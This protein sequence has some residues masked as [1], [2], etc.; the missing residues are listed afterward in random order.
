MEGER[1]K[2]GGE[3]GKI[4]RAGY[5][6]LVELGTNVLVSSCWTGLNRS[7]SYGTVLDCCMIEER[8]CECVMDDTNAP[9]RNVIGRLAA[10]DEMTLCYVSYLG[11]ATRQS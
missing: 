1:K 5:L 10:K 6:L 11:C 7:V 4:F 2:C 9:Y 8:E 3:R